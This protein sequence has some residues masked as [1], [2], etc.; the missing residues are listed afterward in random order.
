MILAPRRGKL[1]SSDLRW[2]S[3]R[4]FCAPS[5]VKSEFDG[6]SPN[7]CYTAPLCRMFCYAVKGDESVSSNVCLL[8]KSG[9]PTTV[10]RSIALRI[11]YSVNRMLRGRPLAHIL[12]ERV[13]AI[14]PAF[15]DSNSARSVGSVGLISTVQAAPFDATPYF[16]LGC[17][18]KAMAARINAYDLI[19]KAAAAFAKSFS[20]IADKHFSLCAAVTSAQP[21]ALAQVGLNGPPVKTMANSVYRLGWH[22]INYTRMP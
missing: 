16:V 1:I 18:G 7:A 15:A 8:F 10:I 4:L 11:V 6:C 20:E 9:C 14:R 3:Q 13:K 2:S 19:S 5:V 17:A 21:V 12:K 22:N